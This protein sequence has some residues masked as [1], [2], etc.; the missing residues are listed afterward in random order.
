MIKKVNETLSKQAETEI[1]LKLDTNTI[2]KSTYY[3]NFASYS[4]LACLLLIISLILNSFNE[5]R[6]KKKN[7]CK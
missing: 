3:Y 6:I 5:E 1:T 4:I 2:S 7:S